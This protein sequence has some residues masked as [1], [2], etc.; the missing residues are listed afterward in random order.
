[1]IGHVDEFGR[2]L[3]SLRMRP[4]TASVFSDVAAWIDTAFNGELVIPRSLIETLNL[5]QS[6]AI[7]ATLADGNE[8]VLESYQCV[9]DWFDE[10]V[11][12]EAIANDGQVPLLG[13]ELLRQRKLT[14]DYV[15]GTLQLD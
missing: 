6:G 10:E 1:V 7:R 9:L 12:V 13:V 4:S 5:E 14:V 11:V 8:V 3:V 2:A 15:Q